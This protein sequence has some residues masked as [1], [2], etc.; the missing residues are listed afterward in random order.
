MRVADFYGEVGAALRGLGVE[1]EMAQPRA[2]DLGDREAFATDTA[3]HSYD[4]EAVTT[5]WRILAIVDSILKEFGGATRERA[6]P[7]ITS[8]TRSTSQSPASRAARRPSTPT[9]TESRAR[10]TRT[11]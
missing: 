2:Y 11:R 3:H 5:Y 7:S 6:A 4:P 10:P 1:V 9:R 8:G